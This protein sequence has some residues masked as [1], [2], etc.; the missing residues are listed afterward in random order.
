MFVKIW[1]EPWLPLKRLLSFPSEVNLFYSFVDFVAFL[2]SMFSGFWVLS[3]NSVAAGLLDLVTGIVVYRCRFK[4]E[5]RMVVTGH[6]QVKRIVTTPYQPV[7]LVR[8][9]SI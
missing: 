2:I 8:V 4:E 5:G 9:V 7:G 1:C 6:I 3:M